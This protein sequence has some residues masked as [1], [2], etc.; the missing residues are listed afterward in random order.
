MIPV[1]YA[2][3]G[4]RQKQ[5]SSRSM[6]RLGVASLRLVG[7]A[8]LAVLALLYIAQSSQGAT[9]RIEVQSLRST[10]DE[11]VHEQDQLQL[12]ALRLQSLDTISQSVTDLQLEPAT[13]S[14]FLGQ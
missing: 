3:A 12:E 7:F 1:N 13:N 11:L 14:E 9:K 5:K 10:A 6:F 8:I 4:N 2:H